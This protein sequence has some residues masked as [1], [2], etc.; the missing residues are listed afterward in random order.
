M[1][2]RLNAHIALASSPLLRAGCP[3][4]VCPCALRQHP[5]TAGMDSRDARVPSGIKSQTAQHNPPPLG[6]SKS[7]GGGPAING[8]RID[9]R[10]IGSIPD[11]ALSLQ[12]KAHVD[13]GVEMSSLFPAPLPSPFSGTILW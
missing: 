11:L 10:C 9:A 6:R 12:S 7:E 8:H 5:R 2:A 13:R 4:H 1:L 3:V